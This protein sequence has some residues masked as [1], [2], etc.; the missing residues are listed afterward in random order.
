MGIRHC[1]SLQGSLQLK[2]ESLKRWGFF[3]NLHI[4]TLL[5]KPLNNEHC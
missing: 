2:D 5:I 1:K 4:W 3:A